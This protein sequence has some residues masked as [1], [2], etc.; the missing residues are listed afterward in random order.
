MKTWSNIAAGLVVSILLAGAAGCADS[1]RRGLESTGA[2]ASDSWI[3]TK[4]KSDLALE[5][6]VRATHIHVKTVD[7]VVTL[8]GTAKS[9]A[10]ADHAVEIANKIEGVKSV[11]NNLEVK[12]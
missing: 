10:E 8:S 6:D 11:V 5:K 1:N 7:G 3:T 2:V 12:S 9:Q 4:V